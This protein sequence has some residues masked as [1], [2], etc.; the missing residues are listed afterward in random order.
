MTHKTVLIGRTEFEG[1]QQ[2]LPPL[3]G[4]LSASE[5]FPDGG[6][7]CGFH[8]GESGVEWALTDW[9]SGV[10]IWGMPQFPRS[11]PQFPLIWLPHI[12]LYPPLSQRSSNWVV[13]DA[14]VWLTQLDCP[15]SRGR[16]GRADL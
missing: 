13:L 7:V 1:S 4:P 12:L 8:R 15:H 14:Q 16:W 9:N 10:S 5:E 11:V 3:G 6:L 2:D